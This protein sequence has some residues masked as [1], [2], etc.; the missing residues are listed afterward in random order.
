MK[1]I[2]FRNGIYTVLTP[3]YYLCKVFG[4]ASY[5]Y[6]AGR[7]NKRVTTDYVYLNYM[8]T[9]IWL[10]LYTVGLPVQILVILIFDWFTQT[11]V[12]T[13]ILFTITSYTS[14][15]IAVLWVSIFK[16]KI[17][18]EITENIS[19]VDNN[20]GY[21]LQ[22]ETY[23]NRK[24]MFNIISE[25]IIVTVML[26]IMIVYCVCVAE[27]ETY[28]LNN[29]FIISRVSC[30]C[31]TLMVFQYVNFVFMMKQ[32]YNYLNKRLTKWINGRVSRPIRLKKENERCIQSHSDVDHVNITALCVRSVGNIDGTL[33]QTD[34]HSLRQIYSELY[35]I[36]CLINDM[37][38]IPILASMCWILT[39]VLCC[40]YEA[41][42]DFNIW[43][44]HDI[45]YALVCL[46]LFF[47]FTFFCHTATN[48][49][50]SSRILVQKLLLDGNCRNKCVEELKM[51]SIQQKV[52]K[53]KYTRCG[54]FTL[55][56][57]LFASVASM[58][59]SY[60]VI[61]VQ[62]K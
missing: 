7:R 51:F 28:F 61:L 9:V 25:I 36:T 3:L 1:K 53:N 5:S 30:I 8:F 52:M 15:I 56:L 39:N 59:T 11:S 41:L 33:R 20:I 40:L 22:E 45:T 6:V 16:R 35:D 21:T 42:I 58:I 34:I 60:I 57:T 14:S 46:L 54:L 43:A 37:Y 38:G 10:I 24:L 31:N 2:V 27:T 19:E 44:G 32:R 48:E 62:I 17:F 29:L 18:L 50:R 26:C 12:I 55:N 49:A 4:L 13:Y 23:M 47:K